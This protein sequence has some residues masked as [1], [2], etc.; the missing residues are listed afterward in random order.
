MD[1]RGPLP[2]PSRALSPLKATPRDPSAQRGACPL[3]P[4]CLARWRGPPRPPASH[5]RLPAARVA[6][7]PPGELL[8]SRRVETPAAGEAPGSSE[9]RLPSSPSTS[10]DTTRSG[11]KSKLWESVATGQTTGFAPQSPG[12]AAGVPRQKAFDHSF[13]LVGEVLLTLNLHCF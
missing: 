10:S 3:H 4:S 12:S 2:S 11:R 5:P 13:P 9:K 1:P 8:R 6:P 7:K